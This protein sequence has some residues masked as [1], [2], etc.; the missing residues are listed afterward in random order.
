MDIA[1]SV[2][3]LHKRYGNRVALKDVTFDIPAGTCFGLLGP[4]GAGKSTTMKILCGIV[5]PDRGTVRILNT[6]DH[7]TCHSSTSHLGY[8]PQSITLHEKLTAIDNLR[9]FGE[10]NGLRDRAL[11]QRVDEVLDLVGLTNRGREPVAGFSGGMKRRLNIAAA[12]LHRPQ[13]LVLDEPTVGVDPQSRNHIFQLIRDLTRSGVTVVYSTHYMEEVEAL[14]S[15]VAI[16]DHGEVLTSGLLADVLQRHGGG[17]AVYLE[18]DPGTP[19][20]DLPGLEPAPSGSGWLYFTDTVLEAVAALAQVCS[21]SGLNVRRLE[22]VQPSLES[23]FLSLTG[24]QMRD[25]IAQ[26]E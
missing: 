18:L 23:V 25:T 5:R 8:V 12:L 19:P 2:N 15:H 24:T 6:E 26:A 9:F 17:Q 14:C 20:P 11:R 13:L 3:H 21:R 22:I 4:N 10:L 7:S 1:V 16:L